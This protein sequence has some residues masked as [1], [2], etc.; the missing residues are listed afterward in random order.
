MASEDKR[1][2]ARVIPFVSDEE[3]VVI[4]LDAGKTVLG[5]MLDLSE[6]GTLI[7]LLA[8]VSELPGEAGLSCV[9]SMYHEKKIFDVPATVVRKNSHLVAFEF[10]S[11]AAEG[12]RDIQAKLIRMEIEWMRLS[13]RG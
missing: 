4:R 7:Y 10:V 13:R 11:G 5:K 9:L 8:D 3:V 2:S 6:L 1:R 12:L